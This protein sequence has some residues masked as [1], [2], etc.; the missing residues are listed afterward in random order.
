MN[1]PTS[2]CSCGLWLCP[3]CRPENFAMKETPRIAELR[4]RC[5]CKHGPHALPWLI[6]N[7]CDTTCKLRDP[8]CVLHGDA[9]TP[10]MIDMAALHG[11]I[12]G[13]GTFSG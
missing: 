3:D 13:S 6:D 8:D 4:A 11:A 12:Y 2:E 10:E 5:T 9:L 1:Q 7:A